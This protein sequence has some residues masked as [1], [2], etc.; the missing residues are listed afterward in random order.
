ML[1]ST[2]KVQLQL[3]SG[4]WSLVWGDL[5]SIV[6]GF[7]HSLLHKSV[8]LA[9]W[10]GSV[11]FTLSN[12][13][14]NPEFKGSW[15]PNCPHNVLTEWYL[16]KQSP[17]PNIPDCHLS[18]T[19]IPLQ[20]SENRLWPQPPGF[21]HSCGTCRIHL[22]RGSRFL[23]GSVLSAR[24]NRVLINGSQGAQSPE[25]TV[26]SLPLVSVSVFLQLRGARSLQ[27]FLLLCSISAW[28]LYPPASK[29]T[30]RNSL[31][32]GLSQEVETGDIHLQR[33]APEIDKN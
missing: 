17:H 23:C 16:Y 26:Q 12:N 8:F 3:R 33:L 22:S 9:K 5:N 24:V 30:F 20:I 2:T 6:G 1:P 15:P 10:L 14:K 29:H 27:S 7:T 21:S 11:F 19:P 4:V 28:S 25:A 18:V 31:R 32:P 13:K